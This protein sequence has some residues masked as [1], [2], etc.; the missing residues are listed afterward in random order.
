M[1]YNKILVLAMIAVLAIVLV[2]SVSAQS[3]GT[4][5][6]I[7]GVDFNIP[8]GFTE[9][10]G[11]VHDNVT[12]SGSVKATTDMVFYKNDSTIVGILVVEFDTKVNESV[13]EE[14]GVKTD[15]N[16]V[17]G[18]LNQTDDG[19]YSFEFIKDTKIITI[20][21]PTKELIEEVVV[22]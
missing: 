3:N 21:S 10:D 1:K 17:S 2:G 6:T 11:S 22:K 5:E 16:G 15:I 19:Y 14:D 13:I 20:M 7:R 8:A 18:Y 12:H 9:T 4:K